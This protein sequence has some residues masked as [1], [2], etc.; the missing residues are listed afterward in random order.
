MLCSA[1]PAI[2][3]LQE[4]QLLDYLTSGRDLAGRP[5]YDP[6]HALRLARDRGCLR[7]SVALFC[8]VGRA[9]AAPGNRHVGLCFVL[10][11]AGLVV[12]CL[13][14]WDFAMA[15]LWGFCVLWVAMFGQSACPTANSAATSGHPAP[16]ACCRWA[17]T[18]MP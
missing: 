7:A 14:C 1:W 2:R 5:L 12:S 11:L 15:L 10:G 9:A 17:C 6:V 18:R 8:E 3:V 16:P 13:V 4:Q